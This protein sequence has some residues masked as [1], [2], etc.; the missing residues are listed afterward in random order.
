MKLAA[1]AVLT[2]IGMASPALAQWGP[3]GASPYGGP[4]PYYGDR[5]GS[6]PYGRAPDGYYDVIPPFEVRMILRS[7]GFN[8]LDRPALVGMNYVVRAWSR[9]GEMVRVVVD[10]RR[11]RIM[12]VGPLAGPPSSQPSPR[13]GAIPSQPEAA[14]DDEDAMP[15][16]R[17]RAPNA[18]RPGDGEMIAPN[19][20]PV[21]R[22][23][24]RL[25]AAPS[26]DDPS[27]A[28]RRAPSPSKSGRTAAVTPTYPP[29]PRPRPAIPPAGET[30]EAPAAVIETPAAAPPAPA[31]EPA[32]KVPLAA[33]KGGDFPPVAP[34][35]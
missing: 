32:A 35:E 20:P 16:P 14:D 18:Q 12:S 7:A 8:P 11:G 33:P 10:A 19:P 31:K 1:T 21:L 5:Y 34:L 17:G 29:M 25:G 22:Y 24:P 2:L 28:P 13:Y 9:R 6:A 26:E 15:P 23:D 27:V 4:G 30:A 3:Y